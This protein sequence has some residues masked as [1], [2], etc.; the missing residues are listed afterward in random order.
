M[1]DDEP[2]KT[3]SRHAPGAGDRAVDALV[4]PQVPLR[5]STDA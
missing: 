4:R 3:P 1:I 2:V 5:S